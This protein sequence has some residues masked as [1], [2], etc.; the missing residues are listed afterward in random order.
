VTL[1]VAI[2][3]EI[4]SGKHFRFGCESSGFVREVDQYCQFL[5][6]GGG[7]RFGS[8]SEHLR[9]NSTRLIEMEESSAAIQRMDFGD[10][11]SLSA[12]VFTEQSRVNEMS[13]FQRCV[14]LCRIEI[15]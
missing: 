8:G 6:L 13:G 2:G 3:I 7:S 10:S 15:P 12:V 4:G 9:R 5:T 11:V 1:C 14:P